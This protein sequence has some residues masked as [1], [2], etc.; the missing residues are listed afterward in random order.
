[1]GFL[2]LV[3]LPWSWQSHTQRHQSQVDHAPK[4]LHDPLLSAIELRR[5]S[6]ES[7]VL[8]DLVLRDD[9]GRGAYA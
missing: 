6:S 2:T 4:T 1:M 5:F 3:A 9:R 7:E 8:Q